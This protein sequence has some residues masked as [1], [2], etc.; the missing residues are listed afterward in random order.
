MAR[1]WLPLAV[2]CCTTPAV[3]APRVRPSPWGAAPSA[4]L[5]FWR[6]LQELA[7]AELVEGTY[8][9]EETLHSSVAFLRNT[10][11]GASLGRHSQ[12]GHT[13]SG[14]EGHFQYMIIGTCAARETCASLC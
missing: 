10:L 12:G 1:S 2:A 8:A 6:C 13:E 4:P 9:S 3:P 14:E 11:T 7:V 5:A